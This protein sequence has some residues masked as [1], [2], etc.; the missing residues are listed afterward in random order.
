MSQAGL[1]DIEGSHPQIPT[2]FVT[3]NGIAVP[4]ANVLEILGTTVANHN[5]PLETTGSGNT[6]TIEAQYATSNATSDATKAGFA[7]FDSTDFAVDANGF[8]TITS[9]SA[10]AF[11]VD[12]ST[13]PGTNPVVPS[14]LG[15]IT[16]TGGQVA[17]GTTTNVIQTNSL[18]ANTY[19]IQIQRSQAV[20]ASTIGDN[21]VSHFDSAAFDVDAN[22]FVQLNGGGIA[23]TSFDVQANTAPG[24]DPVV[25]TAAGV[26]TVNGA[27]V[28]NH[29]V[30]LETRSRAANAY[31]VEVQYATSAAATDG[32]K[33][34]VAHFNS[35][36]F[37]VDA[38]GFVG[39]IGGGA[40]IDSIAVQTGTSP[41]VPTVAGLVTINGAVVAAGTNPV[42]SNGTGANTMALEVQI[43]QAL[44]ATDATRI[45]LSNF[46]STYFTVDANGFVSLNGGAVGLTITGNTGGALPPTAGNWN[47]V[48]SNS[49]F[50]MQGAGSTLTL[51]FSEPNSNFSIGSTLPARTTATNNFIYG[52]LGAGDTITSG[53]ANV[54][55]GSLS[56]A[57]L[58]TGSNNIL[59]G[60]TA[61]Q[62]MTGA[63]QCVAVG[64]GALSVLTVSGTSPGN[65]RN[66]AIG[67]NAL[68]SLQ[69]GSNNTCVGNAAGSSYTTTESNNICIGRN[70]TG[71]I[72]ES[73][74]TRIGSGQTSLFLAGIAA[75]PGIANSAPIMRTTA[76]EISSIGQGTAGQVI[77]SN[78]AGVTPTWTTPSTLNLVTGPAAATDNALARFDGT[79]GKI[80]QNGVVTEDDTGNIS[81]S[82]SVA[83]ASLSILT[84][85]TSNTASATAFHQCQVAGSTA[86]D[87]YYE[88]NINGGQAWVWGLD[89]SDSDAWV[90][91]ASA[92][93]GTTNV[94]RASTA[95]EI[96]YPLQ[97]AFLAY[98]GTTITN[99]TGDGTEYT[100]IFDNEVYDQNADFNLGTSTFT[101]P[102]TGRYFLQF[103]ILVTGGT[104]IGAANARIVTSNRTYNNTMILSP[105]STSACSMNMSV[106]ADMDAA[107]TA[108]FT[109]ATTDTGGKIDDVSGTTS[110]NLRTFVSGY[111]AC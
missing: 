81:Q 14:G 94:M 62:A 101:A 83:G 87:A 84:A 99:V 73:N 58:T 31:N 51:N 49:T 108:T 68:G 74:V 86:S 1:V 66:T 16:V 75:A 12:A 96:N 32:T 34:G 28:A 46:N 102:V 67:Y 10:D 63:S 38:N 110:G 60:V 25:P 104:V 97:P 48:T 82:A 2:E 8:V 22:G 42:R 105:G 30:V 54:I 6:V 17:A 47:I 20:G 53:S 65:E 43:S 106:L 71:T 109:T 61:G 77:A 111:L 76:G 89:N 92:T 95:G 56:G 13:P 40:A 55:T 26:V 23:T 29:S 45:G 33:S 100:V 39:L 44:A 36:Q 19:T 57:A 50:F 79:T 70:V 90:L 93:P 35:T 7:S 9:V 11:A 64:G 27:V 91:S 41:I 37:T 85:N 18:A 107:D 98:V 88:A 78:G 15:V 59:I 80:I 52:N 21:G 103:S 72:G 4:I 3:N 5:I 69:T 24:T